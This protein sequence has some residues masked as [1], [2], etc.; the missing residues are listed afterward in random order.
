MNTPFIDT[1]TYDFS[2]Q[3]LPSQRTHKRKKSK[4]KKD[5]ISFAPVG[6]HILTNYVE[7]IE[8]QE[9]FL[10]KKGEKISTEH[11]YIKSNLTLC[12]RAGATLMALFPI[13]ARRSMAKTN[14]EV[15][16]TLLPSYKE[17]GLASF[18]GA[19][20]SAVFNISIILMII[21]MAI[22][23][24]ADA[25]LG[26]IPKPAEMKSK[27]NEMENTGILERLHMFVYLILGFLFISLVQVGI[28]IAMNVTEVQSLKEFSTSHP[29]IYKYVSG[30]TFQ[31]LALMGIV[32]Y[33]VRRIKGHLF[34][35]FNLKKEEEAV[36]ED[37]GTGS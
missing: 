33:Y 15:T 2:Q 26:L 11:K 19:A 14:E 16:G 32:Y 21:G 30:F 37:V 18:I 24:F 12:R 9:L 17:I 31:T 29:D 5:T 4:K 10:T 28:M 22:V 3:P 20:I 6:V 27:E 13:E 23:A 36:K 34:P 1:D 25:A 35:I 8:T 7:H